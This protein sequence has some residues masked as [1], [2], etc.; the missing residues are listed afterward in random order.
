MKTFEQLELGNATTEARKLGAKIREA[1]VHRTG[2]TWEFFYGD[3]EWYGRAENAYHAKAKGW[4][5]WL[6]SKGVA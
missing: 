1:W 5:A 2:S 6:K 4:E 3:F